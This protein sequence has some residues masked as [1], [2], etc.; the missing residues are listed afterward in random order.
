MRPKIRVSGQNRPV[1]TG[2]NVTGGTWSEEVVQKERI[3]N[4][5]YLRHDSQFSEPQAAC[6]WKRGMGEPAWT[7]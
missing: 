5:K 2:D 7:W 1:Q 4:G 6:S 3:T